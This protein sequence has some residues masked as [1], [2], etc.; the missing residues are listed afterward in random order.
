MKPVF[1]ALLLC[2]AA[3]EA[4]QATVPMPSR[5]ISVDGPEIQN[6]DTLADRH[7]QAV[8]RAELRLFGETL[9][10]AMIVPSRVE[11]GYELSS[12]TTRIKSTPTSKVRFRCL[13]SRIARFR[14]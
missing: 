14:E 8:D 1:A 5:L 12:R 11:Y 13:A 3:P 2:G 4:A 9:A 7:L 6:P 10:R